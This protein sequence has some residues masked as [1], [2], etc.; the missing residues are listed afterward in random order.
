MPEP[1]GTTTEYAV[2]PGAPDS[3]KY[4]PEAHVHAELNR[5]RPLGAIELQR[6]LERENNSPETRTA[7]ETLVCLVRERFRAGDDDCAW[8]IAVELLDRC[9]GVITRNVRSWHL[10]PHHEEECIHDIQ[11]E[12]L[13]AIRSDAP[14]AAFWSV[15]FALCLKRLALNVVTRYR[16]MLAI[17]RGAASEADSDSGAPDPIE[18]LAA[19]ERLS[20]QDRLEIREA[21]ALLT[22]D[23]RTVFVLYHFE[24]W[25]QGEIAA[26]LGKTDRTVR[27]LLRGAKET[28]DRW[29][30]GGA[31]DTGG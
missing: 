14:A 23:Q 7:P 5:L 8:M 15:R 1:A 24:Q 30:A 13:H 26:R 18:S 27:N 4:V 2:P 28:L 11:M 3:G 12:A 22:A 6:L 19:V 10:P 17:E 21:L 16:H 25:D 29:S 20:A 9:A 31:P